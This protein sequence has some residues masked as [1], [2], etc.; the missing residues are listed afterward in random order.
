MSLI[1]VL[2]ICTFF[3]SFLAVGVLFSRSKLLFDPNVF[4]RILWMGVI[5]VE[6]W[7]VLPSGGPLD[8][9]QPSNLEADLLF[10]L[11]LDFFLLTSFFL[12]LLLDDFLDFSD[13]FDLVDFFEI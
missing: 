7:I 1:L 3:L 2:R 13:F 9:G 6:L 12:D 8:K 5:F 10:D 11:L 4:L